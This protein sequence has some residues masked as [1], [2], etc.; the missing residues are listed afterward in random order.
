MRLFS[1]LNAQLKDFDVISFDIFDTLLC[2]PVLRPSDVFEILEQRTGRTGFA[3]ARI[4]AGAQTLK[5]WTDEGRGDRTIDDIYAVLPSDFADL[6]DR[7]FELEKS[8]LVGNTEI[9]V[10]FNL[11][12]QLG[13]KV[14]IT[15]DMYLPRTFLEEVL[16]ANGI[17]GWTR[18]YLSNEVHQRKDGGALFEYLLEDLGCVPQKVLHIGDNP[19][20]DL[21]SARNKGIVA[22]YYVPV[23]TRFALEHPFVKKFLGRHPNLEHRTL[24]ATIA[25]THHLATC[26]K[27]DLS[28]REYLGVTIASVMGFAYSQFVVNDAKSKGIKRLLLVARD[29]Y[30]LEP[31]INILAPEIET[32][33]VYAPRK[34]LLLAFQNFDDNVYTDKK[35]KNVEKTYVHRAIAID[36]LK[37]FIGVGKAAW[38]AAEEASFLKGGEAAPNLKSQL[39]ALSE[40]VKKAYGDYIAANKLNDGTMSAVV[41]LTSVRGSAHRLLR[42]FVGHDLSAYYFYLNTSRPSDWTFPNSMAYMMGAMSS[43]IVMDFVEPIFSAP[44][45]SV[46]HVKDCAPVFAETTGFYENY[47][48]ETAEIVHKSL[49]FS[50][51]YFKKWGVSISAGT[52]V[53]WV[54]AFAASLTTSDESGCSLISET[55]G[56]N[57]QYA[58]F[59]F[60]SLRR[61]GGR[62]VSFRGHT[63]LSVQHEMFGLEHYCVFYLFGRFKILRIHLRARSLKSGDVSLHNAC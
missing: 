61:G 58:Y 57:N 1:E 36:E 21:W 16:R 10:L 49:K 12:K 51:P 37:T 41:D 5:Q 53:D 14:V 62:R 42:E 31:I 2:R 11:A 4:A 27:G 50:L 20:S 26:A 59:P 48:H 22:Y 30:N 33:Y 44:T 43:C 29:G 45:T 34:D 24:A 3:Q 17:E 35:A 15:S 63:V 38:S 8:L 9:I 25:L 6:K 47:K 32:R 40:S 28:Y 60:Y 52:M 19:C 7:E 23:N 56:V 55:Y 54:E 13:K 39:E 46:S 18:F